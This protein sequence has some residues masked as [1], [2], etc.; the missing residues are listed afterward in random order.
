MSPGLLLVCLIGLAEEKPLAYALRDGDIAVEVISHCGHSVSVLSI[1]NLREEQ[2]RIDVNGSYL[3]PENARCQRLG[4]GLVRAGD[5]NTTIGIPAFCRVE[6]KVLS[7]CMDASKRTPASGARYR[8]VPELAPAGVLECL[9]QWKSN[10]DLPQITVQAKVWSRGLPA[11]ARSL[12]PA[13][14]ARVL[15]APGSKVIVCQG[16]CFSLTAEGQVFAGPPGGDHW[17]VATGVVDLWA[18]DGVQVLRQI[19][20]GAGGTE[21]A[22]TVLSSYDAEGSSWHD[23]PLPVEPGQLRWLAP[24]G[25]EALI[26]TAGGTLKRFRDGNST[27]VLQGARLLEVSSEGDAFWVPDQD[28]RLLMQAGRRGGAVSYRHQ[29]AIRDL[30]CTE[31]RL[32]LVDEGGSLI[33]CEAQGPRR[34]RN[35]V[36]AVR[37]ARDSL[38][39]STPGDGTLPEGSSPILHLYRAGQTVLEVPEIPESRLRYLLDVANGDLLRVEDSGR[40]WRFEEETRTWRPLAADGTP[41]AY[42]RKKR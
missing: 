29:V 34:L 41:G 15:S 4:L 23:L 25:G 8:L 7:V 31:D 37:A 10:P 18:S 42:Q 16:L 38:L 40:V 19:A 21:T 1:E 27:K 17:P 11:E 24:D 28:P 2:A 36:S 22:R 33:S 13:P 20:G 9:R 14:A 12:R 3:A 6:V 32:Y 26:L 35:G 39:F 5:S 30:A